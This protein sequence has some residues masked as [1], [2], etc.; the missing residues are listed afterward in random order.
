[1]EMQNAFDSYLLSPKLAHVFQAK[2]VSVD[3]SENHLTITQGKME[4]RI[5]MLNNIE[6]SRNDYCKRLWYVGLEFSHSFEFKGADL[7]FFGGWT[8]CM[9]DDL[10]PVRF[11]ERVE[12][13]QP[14]QHAFVIRVAF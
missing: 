12:R 9:Y 3:S 13:Q 6:A 4:F 5:A 14:I 7:T 11:K 1:M 2:N 10:I 8:T